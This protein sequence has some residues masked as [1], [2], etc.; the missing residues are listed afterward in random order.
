VL[1]LRLRWQLFLNSLRRPGRGAEL[2]LQTIWVLLGSVFVLIT[3]AGF[4]AGTIGLIKIER[5]DFL[6][7]L[8]WAVFLVWQL[9]PILFEGYS[10]GLNFRE[11]ARY[12]IPLRMY[13]VLS[14]VYGLS[15]PAAITALL[16]LLAIWLGILLERPEWA[17][18]ALLSLLLFL[19][20]N[21]VANRL[22]IGVFERFQSTRKGRERM[23]FLML[24]F[25]IL[26]NIV[27]LNASRWATKKGFQLPSWVAQAVVTGREY[28]PPGMAARIFTGNGLPALWACGGLL[29]YGLMAFL[30]LRRQLRRIY[31]GDI[32]AESYSVR[33]ET[34]IRPGWRLPLL[35]DVTAAI[36]EKELR[37][38]RQSARLVLQ[39]IY[40]PVIFLLLAFNGPGWKKLFAGRPQM[41]L[42]GMAGFMLLS[43][44]NLAYNVFG[45]DKE[46]FGRWLLSPPPLRKVLLAKN[47]THGGILALLYLAIAL[48]VA[49]GTRLSL[50]AV[51]TVTVGFFA[52]LV[53]QLIAGNLISVY[54]PK[55]IELTQMSSKMSST[56]AGLASLVVMLTIGAIVGIVLLASW[57]LHLPWLPLPGGILLLAG[58]L[59]LHS[60]V[61]DA[62]ARYTWEHVEEISS[63]LG[64]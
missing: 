31:Q 48:V 16:W 53:M 19:A 1:L 18:A 24:M 13:L 8:L 55:R 42:A 9:A 50:V 12:P 56:A 27:Q 34:K 21:L 46:G 6:D 41:L 10:P 63:S 59:K 62:A 15:D 47:I 54:W 57:Y 64:A 33:R 52:V 14:V 37:Y 61:L 40:P 22:V 4:L 39:L 29:A 23:V 17:L 28:S 25:I 60:V 2:G 43:V 49:V 11:V 58:C 38:I 35:D 26:M 5:A 3:S 36:V 45:M 20:F 7:L 32:Y 30:L 51:A 44:P